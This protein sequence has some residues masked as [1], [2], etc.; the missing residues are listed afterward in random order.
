MHIYVHS[1]RKRERRVGVKKWGTQH[2][3]KAKG[4]EMLGN[5]SAKDVADCP[6]E[7]TGDCHRSMCQ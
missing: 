3:E 5:P 1:E 7:C 6:S 2:M 4:I